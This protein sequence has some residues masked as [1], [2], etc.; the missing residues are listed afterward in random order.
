MP[1]IGIR[2]LLLVSAAV[3]GLAR[4][5]GADE[6]LLCARYI[7]SVP[8]VITRPGHYRLGTNINTAMATGPA[9]II[10]SDS[11]FLDLNNFTLDNSAA[12]MGTEADGIVG[13]NHRDV[14]V[15]NG[16][17]KGFMFGVDLETLTR[18]ANY[19]VENVRVVG[20]TVAGIFVTQYQGPGGGYVIRNNVVLDTGGSTAF[21]AGSAFGIVLGGGGHLSGNEIINVFAAHDAIAI[22]AREGAA[23]IAGNRISASKTGV[24]CG[25]ADVVVKDNVAVGATTAYGPLCTTVAVTNFP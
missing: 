22:D 3:P 16:T 8:T 4:T 20:N 2:V 24:Q 9:I 19:T 21:G 23:I 14:T 15:R 25:S 11:V 1:K 13:F 5:A 6:T 10:Q 12:G 7:T 18:G 17:V